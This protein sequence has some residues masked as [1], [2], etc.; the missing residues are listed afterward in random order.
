MLVIYNTKYLKYIAYAISTIIYVLNM[1]CRKFS[2]KHM[3]MSNV[4]PSRID[5]LIDSNVFN[6]DFRNLNA[7][8]QYNRDILNVFHMNRSI[9][10]VD[11][12]QVDG[13]FRV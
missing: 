7:V 5:D 3:D 6:E 2:L 9:F 1:I 10:Y 13:H 12:T 8:D 11:S 4:Y